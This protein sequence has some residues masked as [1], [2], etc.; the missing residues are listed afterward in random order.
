[1]KTDFQIIIAWAQVVL[2]SVFWLAFIVRNLITRISYGRTPIVFGRDTLGFIRI[3]EWSLPLFSVLLIVEAVMFS[4]GGSLIPESM[5]FNLF[6]YSIAAS[7]GLQLEVLAI[8]LFIVA[9]RQMKSSW[10]A[11]VDSKSSDPLI[12]TGLF[13]VSR[14]PVYLAMFLFLAGTILVIGTIGIVGYAVLGLG[15]IHFQVRQEELA[16]RKRFGD[17][18][19]AYCSEVPRYLSFKSNG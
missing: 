2:I 3:V 16:L 11:G 7:I 18:Y 13:S 8:I 9:S 5:N 4:R 17:T 1:M 12:R 14:N 6:S 10:R 19:E 15:L